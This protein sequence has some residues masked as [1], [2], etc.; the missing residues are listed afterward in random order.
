MPK[1]SQE[2]WN[3]VHEHICIVYSRADRRECNLSVGVLLVS[4]IQYF[5]GRSLEGMHQKATSK[6]RLQL[7]E[8]EPVFY[9][10]EIKILQRFATPANYSNFLQRKQVSQF[11]WFLLMIS[12]RS[13]PLHILLNSPFHVAHQVPLVLIPWNKSAFSRRNLANME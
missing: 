5:Q 6:V 10:R 7:A 13:R 3:R 4:L 2:L 9:L 8:V 12:M 1:T 11:Q